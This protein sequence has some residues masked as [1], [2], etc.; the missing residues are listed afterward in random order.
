LDVEDTQPDQPPPG[1]PAGRRLS[2]PAL[3]ALSI[4]LIGFIVAGYVGDALAPTLVDTHPLV[5]LLLNPRIRN[6]VL[7]TNQLDALT[8]YVV[9]TVRLMVADPLFYM[10]GYFYGDAAVRWTERRAPTYGHMFRTAEKYFGR[11]SYPLV[12]IAPNSYI[13]LFA[14]AAGMPL[15]VFFVLNG[16]GTVDD[17]IDA[18]LDFIGRYRVP[19]LLVTVG[20]VAFSIWSER[21]L[22]ETKVRSL[23][24]LEEEL[25]EAERELE[26]EREEDGT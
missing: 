16:V 2:R 25:E 15:A 12:A 23:G 5:L 7:I 18:V 9:G 13:C 21:R 19:L 4:V 20:L 26:H 1:A 10:V 11:A 17:P 14:G 22:G 6:L 24:H 3:V 8:Y